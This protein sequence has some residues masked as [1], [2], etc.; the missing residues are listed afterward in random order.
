MDIKAYYM[1]ITSNNISTIKKLKNEIA[2]YQ[3]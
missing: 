2:G 1:D 3:K